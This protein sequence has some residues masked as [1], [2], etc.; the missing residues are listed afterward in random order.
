MLS[1]SFNLSAVR[2]AQGLASSAVVAIA[3]L[4]AQAAD[5]QNAEHPG[6]AVYDK[7]CAA[8]HNNPE[9]TRAPAFN[10]LK[11]MRYQT[12]HYAITKGKMQ[13]QASS[14]ADAERLA[15]VDFL[16]GREVVSDEWVANMMCDA[17]NRAV[18]LQAP[19]TMTGFGFDLRNY[20]QLSKSQSGLATGDF[21][22]L[23]L[24]WAIGFPKATTMRA[25]PAI[26]GNT[27]FY[28]AADASRLI[29][30]DI[31]TDKPC[32]KWVYQTETP[33]RTSVAYGQLASGQK[34]V[35]VSD[36]DTTVHLVDAASGKGIWKQSVGLHPFS[37]L[38][39]TPVIRGNRVYVPI[40]Q[41]EISAGANDKHECCKSHG[42]VTALNAADGKA[43]WTA[44]TM[45]DAKPIRDRGDGQMI[46]GPSGA[47][48]WN[49]PLIDE[50]RGLLYV[51]TGEA[52]SEP[53][54]PNTDA[55]LAFNLKDGS[56]KWSFQAT[57]ND[58]FL[59]GCM[60]MPNNRQGGPRGAEGAPASDEAPKAATQTTRKGALNCPLSST[61]RDVDFGSSVILGKLSNGKDVLL[62]GQKSST[63]WALDPDTGKVVW[64]RD[65]GDGT[66]LGG[67][68]WG[69]AFDGQRVFAPINR[70]GMPVKENAG[71]QS[72]PG[73]HSVNVD[74]GSVAWSYGADADCSGDRKTRVRGCNGSYGLSAAPA[75]IDGA[76][77]AGSV[78]GFIRAFDAKTGE[79]LFTYDTA[80]PFDTIN[81]VPG[82]GGAID[83]A[84]IAAA[85]GYLFVNSGYGLF[86]QMPGNVLLAFK[87]KRNK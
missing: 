70:P 23:E 53:A 7:A 76:L 45:E 65:F 77:V 35:A 80:K 21:K 16:V 9:V 78:D 28:P 15:V 59:S 66:P 13:V 64:R 62:A 79:L 46:Y 82:N 86:G 43:I 83:A 87:V 75:V 67:I 22:N 57:A 84:S 3:L 6:K 48:I 11:G 12:I 30:L 34:V 31:A 29:A 60:M 5:A 25:Q 52:T 17:K 49:S 69:I 41:Y 39:G 10:T 38:T 63:V 26:V 19:A 51:G 56:L 85:N 54:S 37:L 24:A 4:S 2:K 61:P 8:C 40:S 47:P 1:R 72:K 71:V 18:N 14:L 81:G 44:H 68:H 58:I 74:D 55:I 27:L 20:R 36:L 73:I 33:L 50:K 42:A 32:I